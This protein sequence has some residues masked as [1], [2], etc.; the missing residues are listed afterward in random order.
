MRLGSSVYSQ[1]ITYVAASQIKSQVLRSLSWNRKGKKLSC[2][3]LDFSLIGLIDACALRKSF[4]SLWSS[5][6][7]VGSG[8]TVQ[9]L[10]SIATMQ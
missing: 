2:F 9:P 8:G 3:P 10:N 7:L 6:V 4:L 5:R 1:Y